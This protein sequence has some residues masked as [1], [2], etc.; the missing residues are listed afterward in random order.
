[1]KLISLYILELPAAVLIGTAV[2][3]ALLGER[4]SML[5]AGRTACRRCC[6]RSP[7]SA[8]NNGSAFAGF[9]GNPVC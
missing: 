5:N 9:S 4:A 8:A 1:M 7:S 6:M 3:V 2:A